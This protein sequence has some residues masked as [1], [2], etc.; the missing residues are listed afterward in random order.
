[1]A[2]EAQDSNM[3][4]SKFFKCSCSGHALNVTKFED[5]EQSYVS[6]WQQGHHKLGWRYKLRQIWHIIKTGTPYEDEVVLNKKETLE[7]ARFLVKIYGK[8]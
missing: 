5:E 7:L 1:M 8:K 3:S 6:I 4:V 2:L